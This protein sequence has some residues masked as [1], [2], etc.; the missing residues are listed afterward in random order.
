MSEELDQDLV[1]LC[2]FAKNA[3]WNIAI[4]TFES[5]DGNLQGLVMGTSEYIDDVI[6]GKYKDDMG[7]F[8]RI[9]RLVL[10]GLHNLRRIC[11]K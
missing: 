1:K 7:I 3:G 5:E 2:E 4:P 9:Y 11:T 10:S 8:D 6:S